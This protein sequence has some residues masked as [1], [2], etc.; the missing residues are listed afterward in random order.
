MTSWSLKYH[1]TQSRV[2]TER[3]NE[4]KAETAKALGINWAKF[5]AGYVRPIVEESPEETE[6]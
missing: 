3:I 4:L 2:P 5:E 6:E 1:E